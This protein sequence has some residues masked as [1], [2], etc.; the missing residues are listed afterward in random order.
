MYQLICRQRSTKLNAIHRVLPRGF[1]AGLRCTER[2]PRN[3]KTR[4]IQTGK[5]PLEPTHIGE[6]VFFGA[7]HFIHDDF[8]C[9]GRT[10]AHLAMNRW[11]RQPFPTF[12][13]HKAANFARVVFCP[14]H[15]HIGNRAIGNPHFR[16]R[17]AVATL[18]FFRTGN[19]TARV[20]AV[21]RLSQTKATDPFARSEFGQVFLFGRFITKFV[22]RQ[23]HERTLHTHHG[24]IARINL[25]DL[26]GNQAIAGVV[27][28]RAAILLRNGCTEQ[29]ERAHFVENFAVGV[30]MAKSVLH[31]RR[32]FVLRIGMCGVAHHALGF[33]QLTIHQK[34]IGVVESRFAH[35]G[36]SVYGLLWVGK[37][38]AICPCLSFSQLT[39]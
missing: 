11:R 5:W 35:G 10:Q 36:S 26:V 39:N 33:G 23:H 28:T 8:A 3:P 12:F 14:N 2:A 29:T 15:E 21:I 1:V 22:N 32:E 31:A 19:H 7:K 27:Q 34:W 38:L 25:L 4:G 20:R 6:C 18:D 13:K 16:A 30:F 37:R 9:N 24:A 17:N